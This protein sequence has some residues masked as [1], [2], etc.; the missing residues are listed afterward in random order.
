LGDALHCPPGLG[1]TAVATTVE[2]SDSV[3]TAVAPGPERLRDAYFNGIERATLGLVSFRDGAF[4]AGPV[5]LI[6]FGEP[7]RT[8]TGWSFPLLGG[9]LLARPGGSLDLK[10]GNGWIEADVHGFHPLLPLPVYRLTQLLFHHFS[11]RLTLLAMRGRFP[12]PGLPATPAA[13]LAAGGIDAALCLLLARG[14]PVRALGL[15][16]GYHLGC[17]MTGGMTV[18]GLLLGQ[19]VVAGDGSRLTFGQAAVRLAGLPVA[20]LRLR[21]VHDEAAGTEVVRT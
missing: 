4:S 19:R 2:I 5:D 1:A 18:G 10:A 11:S 3:A 16:A 13:R 7:A 21:A 14:R 15:A 6:R 17:W 12:P 20:L 8:P 9:L